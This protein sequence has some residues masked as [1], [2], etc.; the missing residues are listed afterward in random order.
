MPTRTR[1]TVE[2]TDPRALRGIA[3]P[4]RLT[5]I[6]LLRREGPL[7]ATQAAELLGVSDALA[8]FHLRQ[9]AKYGLVEEAG[10]GRGRERPW[11]ATALFTQWPGSA[12]T[13]EMAAATELLET[14]IA[15]RYFEL[16]TAWI[17]QKPNEPTEWQDAAHFGDNIVYAT[18][19]ELKELDRKIDSL[20]EPFLPRLEDPGARPAGVRQITLLRLAFPYLGPSPSASTEPESPS[21]GHAAV[22][23]AAEPT[24]SPA[25]RARRRP[26]TRGKRGS[27]PS[28]AAGSTT[29]ST[30]G[31]TSG[32]TT[33]ST[34]GSTSGPRP[35]EHPR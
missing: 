18:A 27:E 23:T 22:E 13:P 4:L 3:H 33:G 24:D 12:S 32:R 35:E 8:S 2:L 19:E 21:A 30:T 11:R 16:L 15:G 31:R 7:T 17:H 9:L 10:G 34:S 14:L 26:S 25:L 29:G 6:G 28:P 1:R 5:L 20:L